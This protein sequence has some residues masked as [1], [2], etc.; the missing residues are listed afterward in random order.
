[1]TLE[2]PQSRAEAEVIPVGLSLIFGLYMAWAI[3]YLV[4][5]G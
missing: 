4:L 3:V 2:A 5:Y 1:M